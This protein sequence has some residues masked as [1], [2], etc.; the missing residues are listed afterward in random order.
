MILSIILPT[1][2]FSSVI[3]CDRVVL[4]E[5]GHYFN[6][7]AHKQKLLFQRASCQAWFDE[8]V[9]KNKAYIAHND[10]VDAIMDGVSKIIMYDPIDKLVVGK[11]RL[12]ADRYGVDIVFYHSPAI[13]VHA[14]QLDAFHAK[15]KDE[16][17]LC[18]AFMRYF[19]FANSVGM[20]RYGMAYVEKPAPMYSNKYIVDA[21]QW[22]CRYFSKNYGHA[23][24]MSYYP[25]T[26]RDALAHLQ[27][28]VKNRLA[29]YRDYY[30]ACMQEMKFGQ[31]A[32]ISM[33]L[34][35]GLLMPDDIR[36]A[37]SAASG[38]ASNAAGAAGTVS[39]TVGN[40]TTS[41]ATDAEFFIARA[42]GMRCY[43]L[44]LYKF[45]NVHML[46]RGV[47]KNAMPAAWAG[48]A[49]ASSAVATILKKIYISGYATTSERAI[50]LSYIFMHG[51]DLMRYAQWANM[52]YID[53]Y[54]WITY[55]SIYA[56]LRK[57][58]PDVLRC[59]QI[60]IISDYDYD[61]EWD[62]SYR[63]WLAGVRKSVQQQKIIHAAQHAHGTP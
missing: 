32:C 51:V 40:A 23:D 2:L 57:R 29:G 18:G 46:I 22:V 34:N 63:T 16:S 17:D 1:Q 33:L 62:A 39:G 35:V 52:V 61:A 24:W 20:K 21:Y 49:T 15:H 13:G 30:A 19:K 50:L 8:L 43:M 56:N 5:D 12:L 55:A 7:R 58:H 53:S 37:V 3:E 6:I 42:I 9:H 4:V 25:V 26:R 28:F 60:M 59:S 41:R 44:Y 27:Y 48:C 54:D 47:G 11:Y 45:H 31:H 36:S 10:T 14:S 38:T